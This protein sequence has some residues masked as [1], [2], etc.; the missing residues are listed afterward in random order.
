[1]NVHYFYFSLHLTYEQCLAYYKGRVS[2][3]QVI[4]DAGLTIRFPATKILPYM[5]SIGIRGRFRL[6]L[7]D[8]NKF[9]SLERI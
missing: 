6:A 5:S 7:D 2:A 8:N 1:M 3:I 9:V 4:D